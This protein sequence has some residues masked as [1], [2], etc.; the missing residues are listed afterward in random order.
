MH[1]AIYE[2]LIEVAKKKEII[3]YSDIA[4]MADLDM[5]SPED[6]NAIAGILDAISRHE[7]A[8]RRPLLSSVVVHKGDRMPGDGF[9]K[10]ARSVG[11]MKPGEDRATFFARELRRVHDAWRTR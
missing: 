10:M 5:E 11:V 2:R 1:Q 8:E 4:P 9:F 3:N 7:H 6:R